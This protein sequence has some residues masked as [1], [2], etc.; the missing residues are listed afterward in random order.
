VT[1][2]DKDF[3]GRQVWIDH[4]NGIMTSYNHL[5]YIPEIIKEGAR[6]K[7]GDVIGGVGNS[8]LMGEAKKN[9]EGI[10]LHLEIWIDGE[11]AGKDMNPKQSRKF[12]EMFFSE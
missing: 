10:H 6:V 11:F 3:G 12:L 9:D 1:F 5:S 7:K 4:G 2:V 8:G